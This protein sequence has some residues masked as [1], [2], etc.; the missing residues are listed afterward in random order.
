MAP[1]TPGSTPVFGASRRPAEGRS[2][3]A[4][5]GHRLAS[6]GDWRSSLEST[7]AQ[8]KGALTTP[9]ECQRRLWQPGGGIAQRGQGVA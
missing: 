8:A 7:A 3:G 4:I 1:E 9:D 6:P 2:I 5:Y